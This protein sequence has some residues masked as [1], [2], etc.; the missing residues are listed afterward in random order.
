MTHEKQRYDIAT[1]GN[2]IVDILVYVDDAFIE[3]LGLEKG[4]KA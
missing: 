4:T 3:S 2:A 1:I